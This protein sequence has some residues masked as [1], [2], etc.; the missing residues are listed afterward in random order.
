MSTPQGSARERDIRVGRILAPTDFSS[1]ATKALQWAVAMKTAFYAELVVL[2]VVDLDA[3]AYLDL[4]GD[5]ALGGTSQL[6]SLELLE[7]IRADAEQTLSRG[8]ESFPGIQPLVRE[9]SPREVI[10]EVAKELGTDLIVMGTHGRSGLARV[11]FGSVADHVIRHS[12]VPV[13]TV[14][15]PEAA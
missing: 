10:L 14:R 8:T 13:L 11:A 1:G 2:H 3:L 5:P 4:G 7:R 15:E 6:V 9:G 12:K